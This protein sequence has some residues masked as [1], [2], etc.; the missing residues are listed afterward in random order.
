MERFIMRNDHSVIDLKINSKFT[1]VHLCS[2]ILFCYCRVCSNL[3]NTSFSAIK[4]CHVSLCQDQA[5]QEK[6][7]E[8]WKREIQYM[9][10]E[11]K[12]ENI[13]QGLV[14]KPDS[15]LMDLNKSNHTSMPALVSI[16]YKNRNYLEQKANL[17]I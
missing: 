14:V 6:L 9:T 4:K 13:V 12:N 10:H 8:R 1:S 3:T 16:L 17:H 15:F 2:L 11:I 7:K 5:S